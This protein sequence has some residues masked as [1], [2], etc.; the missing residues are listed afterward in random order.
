VPT[1]ISPEFILRNQD[2]RFAKGA[3]GNPAG[4]PKGTRNRLTR[5]L[6]DLAAVD[7]LQ[8]LAKSLELAKDGD[9]SAARMIL[10]RAW[11]V[12]KSRVIEGVELPPLKSAADAVAAMGKITSAVSA[13][14]LTLE[15][16]RDL[17]A[18]IEAFRK[19]HEL[20]EI[21]RR[22]SALEQDIAHASFRT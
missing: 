11:P 1:R 2:G 21:E 10:H 14:M 4:K 15:E 22:L 19:T 3:S 13:G 5:A 6:D 7:A 9:V 20:A 8:V 17:T 18:I 16:A 12:P